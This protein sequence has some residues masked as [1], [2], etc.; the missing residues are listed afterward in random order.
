MPNQIGTGEKEKKE[1]G[2][3][4]LY[5]LCKRLCIMIEA[6]LAAGWF[7]IHLGSSISSHRGTLETG[8]RADR[9]G[10]QG[11]SSTR[12]ENEQVIS[13]G[14]QLDV[15]KLVD[16]KK[17]KRGGNKRRGK[18]MGAS[19]VWNIHRVYLRFY[20][21]HVRQDVILLMIDPIYTWVINNLT[22]W[23]QSIY[24]S[25]LVPRYAIYLVSVNDFG[26][27]KSKATASLLL[28]VCLFIRSGGH[29][30]HFGRF[31]FLSFA[32]CAVCCGCGCGR[33]SM[34][35][36]VKMM[37]WESYGVQRDPFFGRRGTHKG[38]YCFLFFPVS[39]LSQF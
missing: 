19:F 4:G 37:R 2:G 6:W 35:A 27:V 13:S 36:T 16:G 7:V 3:V 26:N 5:V 20:I 23:V 31:L 28:C 18:S 14:W 1:G 25:A 11:P 33:A 10:Q 9:C 21:V 17:E 24:S 34:S 12:A 22:C 39:D 29:F 15:A 38:A 32:A 8:T 30:F